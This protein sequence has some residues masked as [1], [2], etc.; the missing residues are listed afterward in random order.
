MANE[1]TALLILK[2]VISDL[3]P[4]D[5]ERIREA[6]ARIR[7]VVAEYDSLGTVALSFV[8]METAASQG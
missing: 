8:M 4:E 7:Q 6:A 2:G 1:Q 5:Q 3:E